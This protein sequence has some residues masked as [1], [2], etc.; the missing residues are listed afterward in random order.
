MKK[1]IAS[2]YALTLALCLLCSCTTSVTSHK[3]GRH[4]ITIVETHVFR[5]GPAMAQVGGEDA[6]PTFVYESRHFNIR[7]EN[8]VLTV[9]DRRYPLPNKNDS[10]TIKSDRVEI[11]GRP[12][13]P[14]AK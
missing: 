8:E 10:I 5:S 11:N 7:L 6:A 2:F 12:A 13:K 14:Q 3:V 4:S 9:N 1:S